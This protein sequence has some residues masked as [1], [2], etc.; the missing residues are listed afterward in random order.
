MRS[1]TIVSTESEW[2]AQGTE[3]ADQESSMQ[4]QDPVA[5]IALTGEWKRQSSQFGKAR[6]ADAVR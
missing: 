6:G 4:H 5:A 1:L 2:M 3:D